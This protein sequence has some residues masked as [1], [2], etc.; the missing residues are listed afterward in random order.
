MT[1]SGIGSSC[2]LIGVAANYVQGKTTVKE[3]ISMPEEQSINLSISEERL[4]ALR[5][6]KRIKT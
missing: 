4:R 5:E 3:A 1:I 2:N 6:S